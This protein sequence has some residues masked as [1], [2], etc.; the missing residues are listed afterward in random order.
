MAST[1]DN[2]TV[3]D[4]GRMPY[5][6]AL[7]LQ[8]SLQGEVIGAR[9]H[10]G[11]GGYLLLVEHDPPVITISRRA[12]ADAHLLATPKMLEDAG[13]EVHETDRGGDITYH[14]PGQL[15]VYPILDLN[16]LDLRL[17]GYMRWLEDRVLEVLMQFGIEGHR[18][19]EATG[20][21][22]GPADADRK[23]CAM[24]VRVSR[25]V[26]MHGLALNVDP[27]LSHFELIIPCGLHGRSITSMKAELGEACPDLKDVKHAIV[28]AFRP[29]A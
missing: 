11:H 10:G 13:V 16:Q 18:D 23:I 20:V 22:V 27:D 14:G 19:T 21:W 29:G 24:G 5:T 4:L 9:E 17:H 15:V 25:W 6:E 2:L 3:R 7:S 12:E 8:R 26:T 1:S 28:N